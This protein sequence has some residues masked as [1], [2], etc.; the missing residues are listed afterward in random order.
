MEPESVEPLGPVDVIGNSGLPIAGLLQLIIGHYSTQAIS[1]LTRLGV[2][3]ALGESSLSADELAVALSVDKTSLYRLLRTGATFRV[4]DHGADDRFTLTETGQFLRKDVPFSMHD[5]A[6]VHGEPW[7]WNA[8][9]HATEAVRTGATYFEHQFG[10]GFYEHVDADP[11][12]TAQYSGAMANLAGQALLA[13]G[14]YDFGQYKRIVDVAGGEGGVLIPILQMHQ[15]VTGV[16]FDLPQIAARAHDRIAAAGLADR[17]TAV[18]GDMFGELPADADC[19]LLSMVVNDHQDEQ[20]IKILQ[21]CRNTMGA[22]GTLILLD[23]TVPSAGTPSFASLIDLDCLVASGG[24]CRTE[25][26]LKELLAAGG[27]TLKAVYRGIS[28][29]CLIEALPA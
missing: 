6:I 21:N 10:T 13:I 7:L 26:E 12:R 5:M 22:E 17:A 18:S 23:M 4:L 11:V 25:Q 29:I 3:D 27:F 19:Y 1:T 15:T 9:G 2:P 16:V 24:R 8:W 28:P 20:A 14:G